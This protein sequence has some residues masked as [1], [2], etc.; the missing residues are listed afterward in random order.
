MGVGIF[1]FQKVDVLKVYVPFS[2][3]KQN[4]HCFSHCYRNEEGALEAAIYLEEAAVASASYEPAPSCVTSHHPNGEI[5][6]SLD[7][8]GQF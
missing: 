4:S 1:R 3:L 7:T 6:T 2:D 8:I 5:T